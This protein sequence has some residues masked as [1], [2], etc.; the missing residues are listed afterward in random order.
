V[1]R[2]NNNPTIDDGEI[3][4]PEP[5]DDAPTRARKTAAAIKHFVDN[6][7][8]YDVAASKVLRREK[9]AYTSLK[10][11]AAKTPPDDV[12]AEPKDDADDASS[13]VARLLK[14]HSR[15]SP[16]EAHTVVHRQERMKKL[17]F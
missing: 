9:E 14:S 17:G 13:K 4:W 3:A 2:P 8:S 15:M 12:L 5:R 7:D 16:D 10:L 6:G 11:I 1:R